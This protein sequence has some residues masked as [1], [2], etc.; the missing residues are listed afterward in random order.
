MKLGAQED[1]TFQTC[2]KREKTA[3]AKLMG[4]PDFENWAKAQLSITKSKAKPFT[5]WQHRSV[6]DVTEDEVAEIVGV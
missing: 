5:A 1:E 3:Q 2:I 6:A 4:L